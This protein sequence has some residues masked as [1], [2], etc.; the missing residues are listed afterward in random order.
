[1][2]NLRLA[3]IGCGHLG[4]IHA[5]LLSE[6]KGVDLLAVV[7]PLRAA[8]QALADTLQ[9]E[10]ETDYRRVLDRVDAAVIATPSSLHARI[11]LELLDSGIHVLMEKPLAANSADAHQLMHS[12]HRHDAVLAVGHVERFNPAFQ[13][14]VKLLQ[15]M[16]PLLKICK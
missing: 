2:N 13:R 4:R 10:A 11:G 15:T 5:R 3:V 14:V 6:M 8:S 12:A 16:S 1:M 7:D 9:V